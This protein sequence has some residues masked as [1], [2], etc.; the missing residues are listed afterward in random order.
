MTF[1]VL[2]NIKTSLVLLNEENL[3][4]VINK[5]KDNLDESLLTSYWLKKNQD[6]NP[7]AGY[8]YY[9]SAVLQKVFP[10]LEI[11]RGQDDMGEYHW[12]N[13]NNEKVI[14]IT[15]DQYYSKGRVPPYDNA[16]KKRQLGGRHG[17]K[18]NRLLEKINR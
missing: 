6:N 5:I 7:M 18:A 12:F 16:E 13:K 4:I 3:E 14:D 8:C 10:E 11:W 17:T 15:E 1:Y 2:K 9:A